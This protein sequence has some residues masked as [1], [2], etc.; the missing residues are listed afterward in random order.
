L[1][2]RIIIILAM[3]VEY[4]NYLYLIFLSV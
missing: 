3:G 4:K 1:K 2:T